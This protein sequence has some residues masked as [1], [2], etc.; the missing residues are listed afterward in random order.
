MTEDEQ[1]EMARR[2]ADGSSVFDFERALV[3]VQR[4]QADAEK[5]LRMREETARQL[6]EL[7]LAYAGLHRAALEFR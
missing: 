5:I 6:E 2:I 3:L 4:R 1:R 7:H